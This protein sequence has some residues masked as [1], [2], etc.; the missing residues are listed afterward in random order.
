MKISFDFDGTLS[1]FEV[2]EI[3][4]VL[5]QKKHDIWIVTS[6]YDEEN[7]YLYE[8]PNATHDD[9][10]QAAE[11]IGISKNK[12]IFTNMEYKAKVLEQNNFDVHF[13]DNE[14]EITA[15]LAFGIKTKIILI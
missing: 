3:A 10:Y 6:R 12:I 11:Y 14:E 9:L 8:I 7:K 15:A 2:Q 5:I 13:D 1:R 4:K